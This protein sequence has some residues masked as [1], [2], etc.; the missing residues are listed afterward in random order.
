MSERFMHTAFNPAGERGLRGRLRLRAASRAGLRLAAVLLAC[1]G[2]VMAGEWQTLFD[3][4][5]VSAW[6]TLGKPADAPIA[7]G[8]EDGA[9]AWKKGGGN[10]ITKE[11]F[12]DFELEL[13]WKISTGGNSGLMFGV[14]E[15]DARPWH[16]GPEIQILDDSRHK[17]GKNT[18]TSSGALYALYA[19][20]KRAAKPVGEWNTLRLRVQGGRIESWL[21][22][23][24]VVDARIG[25]DDWNVRVAKSKFAPYKQFARVSPGRILLQDHSDPVWF[26]N[27]RIRRLN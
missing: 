16:S 9:L 15:K 7:W 11:Q 24:Q 1:T 4:T 27:I 21:N 3:G 5:D 19:P 14:D 6:K 17:D 23:Q 25:S 22:G 12:G 8:I 26:R 10:L 13:E 20:A 2:T 18:L